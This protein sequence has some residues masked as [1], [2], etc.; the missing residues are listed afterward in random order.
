M[1]KN[2]LKF[3]IILLVSSVIFSSCDLFAPKEE[4]KEV[5]PVV[6]TVTGYPGKPNGSY[7][8][9]TYMFSIYNNIKTDMPL[10]QG[11]GKA[12]SSFNVTLKNDGKNWQ[13]TGSF[14]IELDFDYGQGWRAGDAY[15]YTNGG[16]DISNPQKFDISS[17]AE[18]VA[19][20]KFLLYP[21]SQ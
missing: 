4:E 13:G 1:A 17:L 14:Q 10:A 20:S 21:K 16:T 15:I 9:I 2:V 7:N 18:T 5:D 3:M 11:T 12:G 6:I 19:F 8:N